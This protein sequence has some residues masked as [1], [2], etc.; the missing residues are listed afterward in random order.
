MEAFLH[1][2]LV[3]A[4]HQRGVA[5]RGRRQ[6]FSAGRTLVSRQVRVG[7]EI[8]RRGHGGKIEFL[9]CAFKAVAVE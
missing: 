4:D 7:G 3:L 1:G 2:P 5:S 8:Y 9:T 6:R